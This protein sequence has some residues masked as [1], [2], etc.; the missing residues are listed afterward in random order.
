MDAVILASSAIRMICL[1]LNLRGENLSS[2]IVRLTGLELSNM[3]VS[4]LLKLS[5]IFRLE[6][7]VCTEQ[8]NP[9]SQMR[10]K[11]TQKSLIFLGQK[12]EN[13]SG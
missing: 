9:A 13:Q 10:G 4:H 1:E 8:E 5:A 12:N 6:E 11:K 7:F 2:I 3:T